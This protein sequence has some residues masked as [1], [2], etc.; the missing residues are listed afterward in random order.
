MDLEVEAP[1]VAA[2]LLRYLAAATVLWQ[3][4]SRHPRTA[5][6]RIVHVTRRERAWSR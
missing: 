2:M 3:Q 4:L 6:T 1:G 5:H